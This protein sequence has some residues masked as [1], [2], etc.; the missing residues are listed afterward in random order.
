MTYSVERTAQQKRSLAAQVGYLVG[1]QMCPKN[2]NHRDA[3]LTISITVFLESPRLRPISSQDSPSR[4]VTS[5][6]PD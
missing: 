3:R 1:A 6:A 2:D 4:C 5:T